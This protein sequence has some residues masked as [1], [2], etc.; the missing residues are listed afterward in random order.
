VL[1]CDED[2]VADLNRIPASS[3]AASDVGALDQPFEAVGDPTTITN[4]EQVMNAP[5]A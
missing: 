4:T 5:I 1:R 2:F 3:A